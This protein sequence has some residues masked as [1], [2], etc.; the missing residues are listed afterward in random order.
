MKL[1]DRFTRIID[2]LPDGGSITLPVAELRTWLQDESTDIQAVPL[3][4]RVKVEDRL[5]KADEVARTLGVNR[6]WVYR[7]AD[8]LPFTR[9]LSG[10]ALRFSA[11]GLQE[12]LGS[13]G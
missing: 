8:D 5:L 6:A 2:V 10:Q 4:S 13:R 9:R 1:A 3:P 11:N 7:H 12:W